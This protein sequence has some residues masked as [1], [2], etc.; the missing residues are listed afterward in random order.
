MTTSGLTRATASCRARWLK[1]S[2]TIGCAPDRFS[3]GTLSASR[4]VPATKW[5]APVKSGMSRRPMTPVAPA[6]KI[7]T[8]FPLRCA[9]QPFHRFG[10]LGFARLRFFAFFFLF[11]YHFLGRSGDEISVIQLCVDAGDIGIGLGHFLGKPR[12][13]GGKIDHALERQCGDFTAHHKLDCTLG[14]CTDK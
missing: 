7:F 5:P 14:R 2:R 3:A 9:L 11:L 1:T 4:V 13:F 10:D 12:G 8:A 6:R